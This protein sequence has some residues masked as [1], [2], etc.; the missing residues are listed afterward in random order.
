M[1]LNRTLLYI[2]AMLPA[3]L[4][5][6][7]L[8]N[9]EDIF[10]APSSIRMQEML[11][12][13][14]KILTS[15]EEGWIFDYYPDRY[16]SY[17]GFVYTVKFDNQEATVGSELAPGLF[18]SSLYKMTNDNGPVLSF[19]SYNTLMHF[20]STPSSSHYE[21]Y[22][23]DFE[24]IIMEA[25][26]DLITLRG[27][28]TGNE[29][30]LRRLTKTA[31][32]YINAISAVSENLILSSATGTAGTQELICSI[33]LDS[34]YMEFTYMKGDEGIVAGN[35]FIPS[36]TGIRFY[37]PI[38]INGASISELAYNADTYTFSGKDSAGN[39]VTLTG[40]LPADYT[41]FDQFAGTYELNYHYGSIDVTLVADKEN[42]RY[43]IQGLNENY[44]I[45]A[46]YVRSK[47]YL[48][49]TS[50]KVGESGGKQIWLCGW[51]LDAE[52]YF[53]WSTE[54]GMFLIKDTAKEGTYKFV[55]NTYLDTPADSFILYE[56]NGAPPSNTALGEASAPWLINDEYRVP[57]PTSIVKK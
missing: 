41:P 12:N 39:D 47:G 11:D 2:L 43:L 48:N 10:D 51:G 6:S 57:Y 26:D 1:K 27:K 44:N 34:R 33:D 36:E 19:D 18:E 29:M 30:Y 15:S 5:Q 53:S 23:G 14:K 40:N 16:L 55:T 42:N 37:Q 4:L 32:D 8:K 20:F 35:S 54:C 25:T 31:A 21:G 24:F 7:C 28:R 56:F 45:V 49:I 13:T 50:Q 9:Q 52:G 17:G 3:L 46:N 22:D 38:E